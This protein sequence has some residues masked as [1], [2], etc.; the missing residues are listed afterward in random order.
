MISVVFRNESLT[1]TE[2]IME[3]PRVPKTGEHVYI[4]EKSFEVVGVSNMVELPSIGAFTREPTYTAVVWLE[5]ID[6]TNN[7]KKCSNTFISKSRP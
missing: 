2:S 5:N 7:A 3:L 1:E 4:G 6:Y